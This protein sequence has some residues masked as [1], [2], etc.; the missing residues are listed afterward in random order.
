MADYKEG[1]R[2]K[3]SDGNI[4][5]VQGGVPR[6]MSSGGPTALTGADPRIAPQVQ[7]A[8]NAAAA[9]QYEPARAS[10]EATIAQANAGTAAEVARAKAAEAQAAAEIKRLELE[11]K[12]RGDEKDADAKKRVGMLN[13]ATDKYINLYAN[14]RNNY[15]G[16]NLIDAIGEKLPDWLSPANAGF[17]AGAK[18]L[19]S[20]DRPN[21]RTPGEGSQ[22]DTELLQFLAANQP[23]AQDFDTE[24]DQRFDTISTRLNELRQAAGLPVVNFEEAIVQPPVSSTPTQDRMALGKGSN[25]TIDPFLK[26]VA[27]RLGA[28]AAEGASAPAMI[29][30]ARKNG[31]DP[32]DP[33]LRKSIE[34]SVNFRNSPDGKRWMKQNPGK[35]FPVDPSFYTKT[36]QLSGAA[37][38]VNSAAQ[39]FPGAAAVSFANAATGQNLDSIADAVG[40]DSEAIRTGSMLLQDSQPLGSFVGDMAGQAAFEYLGRRVPGVRNLPGQRFGQLAQDAAYGAYQG[41]GNDQQ[42]GFAGAL[43][44][45]AGNA[46]GGMAFRGLHRAGTGLARGVQDANLGYLHNQGV[47]LT[48]G[49]IA[50]GSGG[51][52]GDMIARTEERAAGLPITESIINTARRR[53]DETFNSAAFR[54]GGGSGVTGAQG[55]TELQDVVDN[56]YN[57]L[58]NTRLPLDA[59]FAGSQAGV[60]ANL[61]QNFGNGIADRMDQIDG[62]AQGG[63]LSG[64]DWQSGIRGVRADRASLRGQPFSD[65]AVGSLDDVENNLIGL[66]NRQGG[67]DIAQNLASANEGYGRFRTLVSALDNGPSQKA[68][69]LFTPGRLDDAARANA[70]NFGGQANSIAGNR[71][72]YDLTTAGKAVMPNLTPDSGTAGRALFSAIA[73]GTA[74]GTAGG[75]TAAGA[76]DD[77]SAKEGGG[78]GAGGGALGAAALTLPLMALYSRGGQ[79]RIQNMMLNQRPG[80]EAAEQFIRQH[81]WIYNSLNRRTAGMFGGTLG[82]D[83]A[84]LPELPE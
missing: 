30:F 5:V 48:M 71:P 25:D 78:L 68:D 12:K 73:G 16:G 63:V 51:P 14:Y 27:S 9:S 62:A 46:A 33:Q 77:V 26:G 53:G 55:V 44:G 64:R 6:L 31:L 56:S 84:I 60:R 2:L 19:S 17:N 76:S 37:N 66:A 41:S 18:G 8:T 50:R 10:A 35:A 24:N 54:Q 58:D 43:S 38:L 28:M 59:P 32:N 3:G 22:S 72:F 80:V 74:L 75:L 70:R 36:S 47:D 69:E 11:E 82:R 42:G 21:T 52:I 20:L 67:P 39:S 45:A 57:F 23:R 1:Q 81:P 83:L 13:A 79:R 49:R 15:K 61:P 7:Q 40:G 34:G 4:Y 65:R 29:D